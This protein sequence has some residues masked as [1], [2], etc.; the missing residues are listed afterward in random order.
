[1]RATVTWHTEPDSVVQVKA[2]P[3]GVTAEPLIRRPT[4]TLPC[5]LVAAIHIQASRHRAVTC[6]FYK[7]KK[8]RDI[9]N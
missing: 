9:S 6:I 1:M 2:L 3:A 8:E 4:L 7:G 5:G